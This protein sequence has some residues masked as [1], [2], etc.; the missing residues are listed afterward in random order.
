V[1]ERKGEIEKDTERERG[2]GESE[3]ECVYKK[4]REMCVRE[5]E[6]ESDSEREWVCEIKRERKR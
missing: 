2:R 3:R 6:R 4:G 1:C 5:K